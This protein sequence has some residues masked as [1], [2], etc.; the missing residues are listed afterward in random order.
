M[1]RQTFDTLRLKPFA[2]AHEDH[3]IAVSHFDPITVLA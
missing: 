1:N 3:E 2:K